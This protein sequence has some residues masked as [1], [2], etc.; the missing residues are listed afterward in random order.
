[1][2]QED[3]TLKFLKLQISI[4][5]PIAIIIHWL[6]IKMQSVILTCQK[7]LKNIKHRIIIK[8]VMKP[9]LKKAIIDVYNYP[10]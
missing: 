10:I 6:A 4:F 5:K 7:A 8:V 3:P 2:K 9:K 1:M